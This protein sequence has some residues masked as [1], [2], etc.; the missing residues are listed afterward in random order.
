MNIILEF[1]ALPIVLKMMKWHIF[2]SFD[3]EHIPKEIN[4]LDIDIRN[5][6]IMEKKF[7]YKHMNQ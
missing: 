3:V 1:I 7:K 4:T 6:H 2:D 5:R